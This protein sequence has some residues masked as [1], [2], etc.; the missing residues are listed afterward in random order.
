MSFS[1]YS[2]IGLTNKIVPLFFCIVNQC[3]QIIIEFTFV[4]VQLPSVVFHLIC[5]P[6]ITLPLN[7]DFK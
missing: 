5:F 1:V 4:Y 2:Y 6:F 3:Q 7:N